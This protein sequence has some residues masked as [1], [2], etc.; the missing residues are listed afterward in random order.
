MS[1][2]VTPHRVREVT[3]PTRKTVEA[4]HV[5]VDVAVHAGAGREQRRDRVRADARSTT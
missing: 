5:N 3:G 1:S 2:T 4:S